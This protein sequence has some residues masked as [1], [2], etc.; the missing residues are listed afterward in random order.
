METERRI[1]TTGVSFGPEKE[2]TGRSKDYFL[3]QG[4]VHRLGGW[5]FG[6]GLRSAGLHI[7]WDGSL[8][9]PD[10]RRVLS[11]VRLRTIIDNSG[12]GSASIGVP[13][14]VM[15][16]TD[17]RFRDWFACEIV[18]SASRLSHLAS[19]KGLDFDGNAYEEAWKEIAGRYSLA[20]RPLPNRLGDAEFLAF[21][22][23]TRQDLTYA[24]TLERERIRLGAMAELPKPREDEANAWDRVVESVCDRARQDAIAALEAAVGRN[25]PFT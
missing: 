21:A 2:Q 23:R 7:E 8:A 10:R 11:K 19:K 12:F 16:L 25:G 15:R 9:E 1:H 5:R 22:R 6:A 3:L 14:D 17:E 13:L 18:A 4:L 20:V 24:E